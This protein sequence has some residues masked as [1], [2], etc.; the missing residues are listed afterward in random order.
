MMD[1]MPEKKEFK[2]LILC[3]STDVKYGL[4]R[5]ATILELALR[6]R[7]IKAD[8][9][10]LQ[11][12]QL[13][14][15][16]AQIPWADVAFH[17][18]VPCRLAMNYATKHYFI[19]NP[20]WWYKEEWS[21]ALTAGTLIERY[22]GAIPDTVRSL[23]GVHVMTLAWRA[24]PLLIPSSSR[25]RDQQFVCFIGGSKHKLSAVKEIVPLWQ[26]EWPPLRIFGNESVIEA[27]TPLATG[28]SNI[29]LSSQHVK[30]SDILTALS[31][32]EFCLLGSEAE[33]FGYAMCEALACGCIPLW[34]DV[35]AYAA[36]LENSVGSNG[37]MVMRNSPVATE[38]MVGPR[39]LV[40]NLFVDTVQNLLSLS[41][42]ERLRLRTSIRSTVNDRITVFRQQFQILWN[43]MLREAKGVPAP[44]RLVTEQIPLVAVV[45]LTYN[46]PHWMKLA[47]RNILLQSWPAERLVWVV[48][49][50]SSADK[51][52]DVQMSAF[53][54]KNPKL[55]VEYVSLPKKMAIGGKR[56]RG[57]RQALAKYP[58]IEYFC[59]MDD[60]DVY[61]QHSVRDRIAWIQ[62]SKKEA[63]YSAILPMYD[64]N[65]YTSAV[66][67]PPLNLSPAKRCSEASL[68][69]TRAFWL[70]KGFPDQV[71]LAEG[72]A[73]LTGR[74]A[75]T[76]EISPQG[77]IVS[78]LHSQN[79]SGRSIRSAENDNNKQNGCHYGFT[80]EFFV[81]VHELGLASVSGPAV[82]ESSSLK[83]PVSSSVDV[84]T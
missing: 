71:S 67:V 83:S 53:A 38:F 29:H 59:M 10:Q 70:A 42:D 4:S 40:A 26:T 15:R 62:S 47:C 61:F 64:L 30:D 9:I 1:R 66:N 14:P 32:S 13:D 8:G 74:D 18:E 58:E 21:W 52:S 17:I 2:V 25:R 23:P 65:T 16:T 51:R 49:D 54:E 76:L 78:L 45:T 56:N 60:D 33:G 72:E 37:Q 50:D 19:V 27:I 73:F 20:E 22:R 41:E 79:T 55:A 11:I 5:D 24:P 3:T 75:E 6:E 39:K 81:F 36:F 57:I 48:V 84:P 35:P 34:S 80:D 31:A 68:A 7:A 28:K 69:F 46:R 77:I 43:M 44:P 63:V 82:I 12:L